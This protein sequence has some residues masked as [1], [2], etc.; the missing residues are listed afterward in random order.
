VEPPPESEA[1]VTLA[2]WEGWLNDLDEALQRETIA[3]DKLDALQ[4]KGAELSG[5]IGVAIE[6]RGLEAV[7]Q[8]L[9]AARGEEE[10]DALLG[11]G[12]TRQQAPQWVSENR[13]A[14]EGVLSMVR[15]GS[16]SVPSAK[17]KSLREALKDLAVAGAAAGASDASYAIIVDG[18]PTHTYQASAWRDLLRSSRS[19]LYVRAFIDDARAAGRSLFFVRASDY[20]AVGLSD[21]RLR[22]PTQ[23]LPG[24]FTARAVEAEIK[25]PLLGLDAA[26]EAARVPSDDRAAFTRLVA[27][28]IGRHATEHRSAL[29]AYV[30]SFRLVVTSAAG[31][32]ADLEA[33]VGPASWFTDFWVTVA[34]NARVDPEGNAYLQVLADALTG[35]KPI[36]EVMAGEK[37]KYPA[38]DQYYAVITPMLASLDDGAPSA[39]GPAD[40]PLEDRLP[41]LGKF[42]LLILDLDKPAPL[43]QV[44]AWLDGGRIH[45]KSQREPFLI[46]VEQAY[47]MALQRVE[48]TIDA[49][50]REQVRPQV[51]PLLAR[52]P[53]DPR[54]ETDAS[55]E[56]LLAAVGPKGTFTAAVD[57]IVGPVCRKGKAAGCTAKAP[58]G[59]RAVKVPGEAVGLAAWAE[60]LSGALWDEGGKPVP[61]ALQVRPHVL[62]EVKQGAEV[63]VTRS[64]LRSGETTVYG[65]NQAPA[66][67]ALPVIWFTASAASAGMEQIL[68]GSKEAR[69]Q[70][71]EA[72]GAAWRFYRLL[73]RAGARAEGMV[74]WPFDPPVSFDMQP[75]PWGLVVPP[76]NRGRH[77]VSAVAGN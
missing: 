75:D 13:E 19:G 23:S 35:F 5:S 37:G 77:C 48:R 68:V 2:D 45:E 27:E 69:P 58:A 6:V 57:Q 12:A 26:L 22:G 36:V 72:D 74:T 42:G 32:R 28:G 43:Q 39:P 40:A 56:D 41:P 31:L 38:L 1:D 24:T 4:Q 66:W 15:Q 8:E 49:A 50:W 14:L 21:A 62:P 47:G 63:A 30:S 7:I 65:F 11:S 54:A 29:S 71:I 18:S 67:R 3:Q 20:P 10:V 9:K 34:E 55:P 76:G 51:A 59:Y 60:S 25:P 16:L 17:G 52:F 73:C 33:M 53:L 64:F 61:I 70:T 44:N 46:P